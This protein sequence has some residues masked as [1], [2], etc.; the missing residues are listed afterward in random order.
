MLTGP[1]VV[2]ILRKIDIAKWYPFF[3]FI[4]TYLVSASNILKYL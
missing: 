2:I 4:S 3:Y 1:E